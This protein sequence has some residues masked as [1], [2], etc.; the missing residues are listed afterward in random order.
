MLGKSGTS[1]ATSNASRQL[2][3]LEKP[4][5]LSRSWPRVLSIQFLLI[6]ILSCSGTDATAVA[7]AGTAL[8][9]ASAGI[10]TIATSLLT[11]QA[12]PASAR[13]QVGAGLQDALSALSNVTGVYHPLGDFAKKVIQPLLWQTSMMPSR[14]EP[15]WWRI[16]NDIP[17]S[18]DDELAGPVIVNIYLQTPILPR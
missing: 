9:S 15:E 3:L 18:K 2:V 5:A 1:N 10:K 8:D 16:A 12:A 17:L 7:S 13:D 11:G 14:R 4:K 6:S